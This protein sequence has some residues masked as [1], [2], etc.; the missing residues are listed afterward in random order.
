VHPGA[1]L[2]PGEVDEIYRWTR[3]DRKLLS[4]E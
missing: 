4:R 2:S 3:A 1:K